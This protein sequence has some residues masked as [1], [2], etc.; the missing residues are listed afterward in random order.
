MPDASFVDFYGVY[1]VELILVGDDVLATYGTLYDFISGRQSG[2]RTTSQHYTDVVQIRSLKDY[3]EIEIDSSE[4][5]FIDNIPS[6]TLSFMNGDKIDIIFPD[7][8]YFKRA[9][10]I[11]KVIRH[12][13]DLAK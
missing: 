4:K 7:E 13:V 3:R 9:D 12:K 11:I 5:I 8:E 10:N 1:N 6:L 2:E